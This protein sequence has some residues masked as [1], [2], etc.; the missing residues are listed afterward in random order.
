MPLPTAPETLQIEIQPY[1]GATVV[2]L[3]GSANMEVAASL[4]DR[5]IALLEQ[6][7]A[8]LVLDLSELRFITSVGLGGIIAAHL[9]CRHTKNEIRLVSP[10][11]AILELLEITKLTKLFPIH[12]TVESAVRTTVKY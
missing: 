11:P 12:P 10:Q 6:R 2:K 1:S 8:P 9:H 7:C 3:I 4:R 5:L